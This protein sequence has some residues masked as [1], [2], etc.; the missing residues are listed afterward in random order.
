MAN[1]VVGTLIRNRT[2]GV[3]SHIL[4][5]GDAR[6]PSSSANRDVSQG[7]VAYPPFFPGPPP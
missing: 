4:A 1:H 6:T 5:N 3:L 2:G 7:L